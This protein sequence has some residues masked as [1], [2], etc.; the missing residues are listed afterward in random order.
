MHNISIPEMFNY[1]LVQFAWI[2]LLEF[3]RNTQIW[4]YWHFFTTSNG[5]KYV[6]VT[7][8]IKFDANLYLSWYFD[9]KVIQLKTVS[10]LV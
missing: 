5:N 4:Q 1:E 7:S 3:S 2:N 8:G 10:N 9:I 6:I